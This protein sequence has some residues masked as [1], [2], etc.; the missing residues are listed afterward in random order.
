MDNYTV[1]KDDVK[2]TTKDDVVITIDNYGCN[3]NFCEY[4]MPI[5][6]VTDIKYNVVKDNKDPNF[7]YYNLDYNL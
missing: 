7:Y 5:H 1:V 3:S 4:V 2:V 6:E